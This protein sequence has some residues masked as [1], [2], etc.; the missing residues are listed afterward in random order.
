MEIEDMK[1]VLEHELVP[2]HEIVSEAKGEEIL[3]EYGI[4]K[5]QLPKILANDPAI[6]HLKAARGNIIKI[7][8]ASQTAGTAIYYRVVT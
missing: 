8:R 3:I 1:L 5:R 6:K 4:I 2:K 7:T